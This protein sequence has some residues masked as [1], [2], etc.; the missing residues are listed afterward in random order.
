M[1]IQPKKI[2]CAIDFSDYTDMVLQYGQAMATEF[3]AKLYLCHVVS[4]AYMVSSHMTPYVDYTS[5]ETERLDLSREKLGEMAQRLDL[6]CEIVVGTG[7]PAEAIGQIVE[8]SHIEM[9]IAATYGGSGVKRF[10]I[11]SVTDRLVSILSCPLL[12]LHPQENRRHPDPKKEIHLKRILVGCDFSQDSQLAFDYALSLAQEFQTQLYLAHV[13]PH[14]EQIESS[15]LDYIKLQEGDSIG[16]NRSDYLNLQSKT[17]AEDQE[18]KATLIARLERQLLYMVPQECQNFCTPV[19]V[20]LEGH[21]YKELIRY[22]DHKDVDMIVL[23]IR[24]HGLIETFLV[25]STTDRV[26]SRAAC[27]V[28]AIRQLPEYQKPE[29]QKPEHQKPEHQKKETQPKQMVDAKKSESRPGLLAKDI[30]ETKVITITSDTKIS[31]A[32]KILLENHINGLPVL[33]S[34]GSLEGILCQSDLIYQQKE[35]KAPPIFSM[36]DSFIPLASSKQL[37]HEI[38][39]ISALTVNH[40]M[41]KDP[42]TVDPDM[43]ISKIASLMVDR[44]FHTI[45]VVESGKLVGVIGQEDILKVLI[46]ASE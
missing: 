23:G 35:F 30:M 3:G 26:I 34:K 41:V 37:D 43:P 21:P 39:K 11:G 25:G 16:W 13:I 36:L 44:H 22:A 14:I 6:D 5:I 7:N 31:V 46:T 2:M 8:D 24:G 32:V 18:K 28:L 15:N 1:R 27:P 40:A 4:S 38:E 29:Y 33:D 17:L 10:L 12:V 20:I 9:V 42:R 45:P 19:T